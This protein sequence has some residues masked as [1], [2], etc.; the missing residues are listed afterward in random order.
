MNKV[1]IE[2]KGI[3]KLRWKGSGRHSQSVDEAGH[4]GTLSVADPVVP[5]ERMKAVEEHQSLDDVV[6]KLL[7]AGNFA[8]AIQRIDTAKAENEMTS[9]QLDSITGKILASVKLQLERMIQID[10][11]ADPGFW[12]KTSYLASTIRLAREHNLISLTDIE[13]LIDAVL[14]DYLATV[15]PVFVDSYYRFNLKMLGNEIVNFIK[16]FD[17]TADQVEQICLTSEQHADDASELILFI[18][19]RTNK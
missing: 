14:N 6:E 10:H 11:L 17:L 15:I 19:A 7:G 16:A 2:E 3:F 4:Q 13:Q 12:K 5:F 18:K 9:E 1:E 8:A